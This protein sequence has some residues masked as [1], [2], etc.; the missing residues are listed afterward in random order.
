[1]LNWDKIDRSIVI[2]AQSMI[3]E[4]CREGNLM[5]VDKDEDFNDLIEWKLY[6]LHKP[7]H[8]K[9]AKRQTS[10][11]MYGQPIGDRKANR[12]AQS[13]LSPPP[14]PIDPQPQHQS[15]DR[16]GTLTQ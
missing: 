13:L 11:G 5:L 14:M 2:N 1:M 6:Q 3:K 15:Q 9:S 8:Q 7:V 12:R 10:I 4:E 16:Q